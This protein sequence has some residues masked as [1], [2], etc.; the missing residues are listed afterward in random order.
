MTERTEEREM[1]VSNL[2]EIVIEIRGGRGM[3]KGLSFGEVRK[4]TNLERTGIGWER[5]KIV[6]CKV[7]LL[8]QSF[9]GTR[10]S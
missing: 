10:R 4:S 9:V 3:A 8:E 5:G 1:A 7:G 6:V 2:M